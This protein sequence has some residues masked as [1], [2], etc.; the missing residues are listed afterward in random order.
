MKSNRSYTT[1]SVAAN[2]ITTKV[3]VKGT[4]ATFNARPNTPARSESE[5]ETTS[6]W[7][8]R[9]NNVMITI[10]PNAA[11]NDA[12]LTLE[13]VDDVTVDVMMPVLPTD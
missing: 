8:N 1:W 7:N 12:A 3:I 4:I 10:R 6:F 9:T 2:A 13:M 5:L 11:A